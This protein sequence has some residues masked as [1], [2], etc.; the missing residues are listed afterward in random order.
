MVPEEAIDLGRRVA[1]ELDQRLG[2]AQVEPAAASL[3]KRPVR[4]LL[5]K[6]VTEAVLG[7]RPGALLDDELKPLQLRERRRQ[8]CLRQQALQQR[9]PERA[10]DHRGG[11]DHCPRLRVE[12]VEARLERLLQRRRNRDL[13]HEHQAAVLLDQG[14]SLAQVP[15]CLA[16]EVRIAPGA[17]AERPGELVRQVAARVH[18]GELPRLRLRERLDFELG[19][20]AAETPPRP[21]DELP[22]GMVGIA[23]MDE[24]E[25][26][27][28]L[29]DGGQQLVE[30]RQRRFIRPVQV[31][32]HEAER[33][34]PG[35]RAHEP[36]E[37]VEG[38]VL[39]GVARQV[40]DA[41]LVRGLE[42]EA[43][44]L[45]EERVRVLRVARERACEL[46]AELEP[47]AC[48]RLR[49]AEPE[50]VPEQL[51]DG[52]VRDRLGV[53]DGMPGE[54][55]HPPGEA[56]LGLGDEPRFADARLAGDGDDRAAALEQAVQGRAEKLDLPRA[57][58][59]RGL[60]ARRLASAG[61][62]DAERRDRR[63]LALE[64][65]LAEVVELE[66]RLDLVCRRRADDQVSE[67]LQACGDVHGVAE[68]VVELVGGG[69]AV[70]DHHGSR[71]HGDPGGE[72][73]PDVGR[74][75]LQRLPDRDRGPD[76]ALRVVLVRR[77][78]C[79]RAPARR[80]R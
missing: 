22:G 55:A 63:A 6:P 47:D 50:P 36:L 21:V 71:V 40:A 43:E 54:K 75:R 42:R 24:H 69:V 74:I 49:D 10:P 68:R 37:P 62:D 34:L 77:R 48:L 9:Q 31:V 58:D 65:L 60:R 44:Q 7:P 33:A 79:R 13:A 23:A 53:R 45:R 28:R 18:L 29:L 80:P 20:G 57:A 15:D 27:R 17:L 56:L 16:D 61:P 46:G 5:H 72:L 32:E 26:D 51:P 39:D 76:R 3:R 67:R 1:V 35:E 19:E 66:Q 38:L 25:R 11:R 2:D 41:R 52:P 30:Q 12:P 64:R 73:D 78:A 14:A 59:E 8:P 4:G 70:R